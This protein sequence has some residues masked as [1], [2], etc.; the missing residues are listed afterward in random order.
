MSVIK[1]PY[2]VSRNDCWVCGGIKECPLS[3]TNNVDLC[4]RR[5]ARTFSLSLKDLNGKGV[6]IYEMNKYLDFMQSLKSRDGLT[7]IHLALLY[8][9]ADLKL[10]HKKSVGWV[11]YYKKFIK[12]E[13]AGNYCLDKYQRHQ[14]NAAMLRR[15]QQHI[16]KLAKYYGARVIQENYNTS[17]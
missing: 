7:G 4:D 16:K 12:Y 17:K 8:K 6:A 11:R 14:T 5:L 9:T 15:L 1:Y 10:K 2:S 13:H 3:K